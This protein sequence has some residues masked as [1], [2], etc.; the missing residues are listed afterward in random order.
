M[1]RAVWTQSLPMIAANSS[2]EE[3]RCVFCISA[4]LHFI[5]RISLADELQQHVTWYKFQGLKASDWNGHST[6][7]R[8][9]GFNREMAIIFYPHRSTDCVEPTETVVDR[10]SAQILLCCECSLLPR[11]DLILSAGNSKYHER[12][13]QYIFVLAVICLLCH[14]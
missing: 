6:N 1:R 7:T 5:L 9:R 12:E 13:K 4:Y 10:V 11:S 3:T 2:S 14:L 8:G